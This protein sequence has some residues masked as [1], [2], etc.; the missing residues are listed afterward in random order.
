MKAFVGILVLAAACSSEPTASPVPTETPIPP[1]VDH[2]AQG[3]WKQNTNG[4]FIP[5]NSFVLNLYETSGTIIGSGTFTYEAGPFGGLSAKGAV[6]HDTLQL[7]IVYAYDPAFQKLKPDT[8]QFVGVLINRDQIDGRMTLRG[9]TSAF[10]L[11]RIPTTN[12]PG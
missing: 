7:Q 4:A 5:G 11:I 12:P 1:A 6:A 8:A 10:A 2:D 3:P 9:T